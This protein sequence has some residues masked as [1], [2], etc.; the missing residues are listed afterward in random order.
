MPVARQSDA[1]RSVW[2]HDQGRLV[3]L[4]VEQEGAAEDLGEGGVGGGGELLGG[5]VAG[6]GGGFAPMIPGSGSASTGGALR[7]AAIVVA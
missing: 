2:K 5:V 7:A 3:A 4:F 1:L 6:E